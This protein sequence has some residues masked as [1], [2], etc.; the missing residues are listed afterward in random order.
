[1]GN[2]SQ[3]PS[4]VLPLPPQKQFKVHHTQT[5]EKSVNRTLLRL[6]DFNIKKSQWQLL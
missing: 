1:M 2:D 4:R 5:K 3:P 6:H